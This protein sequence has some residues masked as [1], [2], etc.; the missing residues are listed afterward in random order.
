MQCFSVVARTLNKRQRDT[1]TRHRTTELR[2]GRMRKKGVVT[3][4]VVVALFVPLCFWSC[5]KNIL[6]EPKSPFLYIFAHNF[7]WM[8]PLA[9]YT[10]N[11]KENLMLQHLC[12]WSAFRCILPDESQFSIL[13]NLFFCLYLEQRFKFV[14][15]I[16]VFFPSSFERFEFQLQQIDSYRFPLRSSNQLSS[17]LIIFRFVS[18]LFHH[19]FMRQWFAQQCPNV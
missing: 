16:C 15:F 11:L 14:F 13:L 18:V 4:V 19:Q 12:K 5:S 1:Q 17:S 8:Q 10:F 2:I 7:R 9:F 3:A 6:A